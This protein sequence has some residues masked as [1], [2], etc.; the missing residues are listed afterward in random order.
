MPLRYARAEDYLFG[1]SIW[2]MSLQRVRR[3]RQ[4]SMVQQREDYHTPTFTRLGPAGEQFLK[5]TPWAN[6]NH[7]VH[8]IYQQTPVQ[9]D[10]R[11]IQ[12][13]LMPT[14]SELNAAYEAHALAHRSPTV[15][16]RPSES[17]E[18]VRSMVNPAHHQMKR[19]TS[20]PSI[21]RGS[22]AAAA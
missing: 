11:G 5:E 17:P 13:A 2:L 1:R 15:S 22:K 21:G 6:P 19:V 8:K 16:N 3:G 18:M 14:A 7:L 12:Q 9:Q 4:R 20:I 10:G